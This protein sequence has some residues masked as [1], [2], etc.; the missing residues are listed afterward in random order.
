MPTVCP[1]HMWPRMWPRMCARRA[2]ARRT[3][4]HTLYN[5]H[6]ESVEYTCGRRCVRGGLLD[7]HIVLKSALFIVFKSAFFT[8]LKSRRYLYHRPARTLWLQFG[9][10][11]FFILFLF[12]SVFFIFYFG[13]RHRPGG[14]CLYR[15]PARTLWLRSGRL[16]VVVRALAV[17]DGPVE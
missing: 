17:D 1:V 3:L 4:Q 10:L 15:R 8:V 13:T 2:C 9:G 11:L 6:R 14:C 7:R 12:T 16:F 5:T